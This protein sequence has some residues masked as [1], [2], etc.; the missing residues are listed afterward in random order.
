MECSLFALL[1]CFSWSSLYIDGGLSYKDR[2]LPHQVFET[3][4]IRLPGVVET[5]T[6]QHTT[7][8][9]LNP[10]GRV[11]VGYELRFTSITLSLEAS[12]ASSL[13]TGGDRGVNALSIKARWYPFGH[14]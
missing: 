3:E 13:D 1:A 4:V 9:P 5:V 12:H 7:D 6:T 11:A 14:R 10:Y 2:E 8:H